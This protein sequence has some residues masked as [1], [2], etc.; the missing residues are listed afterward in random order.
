[1]L[2]IILQITS[3]VQDTAAKVATQVQTTPV[4][5]PSGEETFSLWELT[6]KGGPIMI[7]IALLSVIA[8]YIFI[9]RYS[10]V[11]RANRD[12]P[13]FMNSIKEF[14]HDGKID[15]A[16]ALCK[17]SQFPT[18]RLIEKGISNLGKPLSDIRSAIENVGN[19][20]LSKLE[21]NIGYLAVCAGAAPM[22]G[23]LGTVTGMVRAFYHMSKAGNNIEISTLS[24]GI[25]EAM[26]TTVAGLIVG[27]IAYVMY[28]LIVINVRKVVDK[29][30]THT[31]EF[32]DL[33]NEP[34]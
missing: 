2:G 3:A 32:I 5:T 28:N 6:M 17:S 9:E 15:A 24:S 26:V 25:Y 1:M 34:A 19:I 8:I 27:I 10:A 30:E 20:E 23:F 11:R 7:P 18:A 31:I 33:L 29:M 14:I 16:K 12:N 13:G 4:T 21:K 22:L